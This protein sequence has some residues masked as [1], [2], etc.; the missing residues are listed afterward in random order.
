MLLVVVLFALIGA[1]VLSGVV[2]SRG[3]ICPGQRRRLLKE[4]V[5]LLGGYALTALLDPWLLLALIPMGIYLLW[6]HKGWKKNHDPLW[7]L[8]LTAAAA[9]AWLM[10]FAWQFSPAALV[11]SVLACAVM[12]SSLMH[13]ML[14]QAKSRLQAFYRILPVAG[15]ISA[16]P[17][18][19]TVA[20]A[21]LS[22]TQAQQQ[23]IMATFITGFVMLVIG[24]VAW[25][26]SF[27]RLKE[28][29]KWLLLSSHVVLL[30][31]MVLLNACV[32]W[33]PVTA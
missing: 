15:I 2:L 20:Y 23:M 31:A 1:T 6:R 21:M 28:M 24:L 32:F 25:S 22:M 12:G 11:F 17:L 29:P 7:L 9:A 14:L 16:M 8:A 30:L 5:I 10:Q 26:V 27:W 13:V 3:Q 18:C 33:G 19:L 4:M